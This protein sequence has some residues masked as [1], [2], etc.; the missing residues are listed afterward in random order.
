MYCEKKGGNMNEYDRQI[1]LAR[2]IFAGSARDKDGYRGCPR[3]G[4]R[5]L[6]HDGH[7]LDDG[8]IMC[9]E[10]NYSI[11][12]WDP[13]EMVSRW[14]SLDRMSFQLRIPFKDFVGKI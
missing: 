8:Y 7:A 5:E 9:M 13:Y 12:G 4:S 14:N 1:E 11:C 10:C 2:S 6:L 3:C